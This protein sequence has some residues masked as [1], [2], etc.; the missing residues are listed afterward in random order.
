MSDK[1]T[2]YDPEEDL[3]QTTGSWEA[4]RVEDIATE[5]GARAFSLLFNFVVRQLQVNRQELHLAKKDI[6]QL[7]T[8]REDLR[9]QVAKLRER[10][11]ASWLHA[12]F[13]AL[14]GLGATLIIAGYEGW[15]GPLLLGFGI[16]II[17][18]H[19]QA[20]IRERWVRWRDRKKGDADA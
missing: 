2:V 13:G 15:V 10:A 19:R 5:E 20:D 3:L 1:D 8:D 18:G 9:E 6:K 4:L 17:A 7:S 12:V 11:D 14:F 16:V